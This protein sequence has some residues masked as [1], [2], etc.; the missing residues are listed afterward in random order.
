[1]ALEF[2]KD[3]EWVTASTA[4]KTL[5]GNLMRYKSDGHSA[6]GFISGIVA[7]PGAKYVVWFP[8]DYDGSGAI[9]A[10]DVSLV[11]V[12][13]VDGNTTTSQLVK[14]TLAQDADLTKASPEAGYSSIV[15]TLFGL[16][17]ENFAST[18]ETVDI[19]IEI[20]Y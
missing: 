2:Q 20:H 15:P 3:G 9:T 8:Y 18:G 5:R 17:I 1:M 19:M 7:P 11:V 6:N 14:G 12:D 13:P 4:V 16:Q 10:G